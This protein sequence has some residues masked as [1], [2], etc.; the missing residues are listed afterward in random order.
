MF[1][2]TEDS[3]FETIPTLLPNYKN[4]VI[5][6][7]YEDFYVVPIKD[8]STNKIKNH[9]V[10][11]GNFYIRE[12]HLNFDSN[13]NNLFR[14]LDFRIDPKSLTDI[15]DVD[16]PIFIGCD[17]AQELDKAYYKGEYYTNENRK[18]NS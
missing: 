10:Q 11:S 14:Y 18:K 5:G 9:L 12:Y 16:N 7:L 3:I 17:L 2:I 1:N 13:K 8:A 6:E 15:T 4:K